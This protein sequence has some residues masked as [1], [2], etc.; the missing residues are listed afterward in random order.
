MGAES[1]FYSGTAY[2]E[3]EAEA[4]VVAKA[5]GIVT[6]LFVEEGQYVE[7]GTPLAKLDDERI[8]LEVARAEV[9]LGKLQRDLERNEGLHDKQLISTEEFERIRSDY[10]AQ[11]AAY[12]L[13]ALDLAFTTVRAPIGGI[14]SQ[15]MIKR[16]N[17]L[18]ANEPAFQIT[19]FSPLRAVM[20]LP[21]R[22]LG[23]IRVGQTAALE[24]DALPLEDFTGRVKLISPVVDPSTGTF[25][26]TVEVR[27][28]SRA[29]KPGMFG[30]VHIVYDTR[31][32]IVLVPK[33]AVMA[34]DD[35]ANVF[36]I[37]EEGRAH[38]RTVV[39]G[40]VDGPRVEIMEGLQAGDQVIVVGQNAL[41]DS[42]RV[43]VINAAPAAE[44]PRTDI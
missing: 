14:I 24:F 33:E 3:A 27:D 36:V 20:H 13:A 25:R 23:K 21:E 43:E 38:R 22:E 30:R 15:R 35:A 4:T 6:G 29:V 37:D 44:A 31:T 34:E 2:I 10:E 7:Q 8:A 26:V 9:A 16:G 12:D 28:P 5:T 32:D 42:T 41:R 11:K 17:M 40:Y 19:S 1:A 39:T 18:T